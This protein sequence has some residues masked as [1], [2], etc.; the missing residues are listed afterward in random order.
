MNRYRHEY[1]YFLDGTKESILRIRADG[2]LMRDTHVQADGTYFIRSLYFDDY[3]DSCAKENEAGTDPRSKF[4]IRYYNN[5]TTHIRLEKK[6][7]TRGMTLKESC[8]LTL[9]ECRSFVKGE[10]PPVTDDMPS[11]KQNLFLEMQLRCLMPKVIVSYERIPYVYPG[12][13]VRVT[14][15]RNISSSVDI[16]HFLDGTYISRPILPLG[17]SILEVK[18]DEVMPLHIKDVLALDQLQWTAF[19]KYYMCRV[20]HL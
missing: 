15:D 12:G 2:I 11:V 17:Q 10:I 18:W 8:K 14:F 20:Y 3:D 5:D 6:S 9:E 4:R 16:S 1:K 7:K 19:S 13:N